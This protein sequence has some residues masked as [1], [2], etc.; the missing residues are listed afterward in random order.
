M[1][2]A[3]NFEMIKQV[4]TNI[5][6]KDH[7]F[8]SEKYLQIEFIIEAAKIYPEYKYYPELVPCKIP[9]SY[10]QKYGDN[11][12]HFDLL[13]FANNQKVL[14]EFKYITNTYEDIVDGINIKVKS[15]MALNKR[16]YDCWNDIS[17]IERF[18]KSME[19]DIDYGF[20]VLIS[21]VPAL[22]N[23]KKRHASDVDFGM[24]NGIHKA[25][26]KKW[27]NIFS[28]TSIKWREKDITITNDY[29]FRYDLFY[30]SN[31]AHGLFKSL[32]VEIE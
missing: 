28:K 23:N 5:A 24:E 12:V 25:K 10:L 26:T 19:S 30:E 22:W 7:F 18:V 17:R 15:H 2:K 14:I 27:C 1:Y 8:V 9:E 32:V 6:N 11:G 31:K 13:I 16:R 20:F 21:N 3:I 29:E 4:L